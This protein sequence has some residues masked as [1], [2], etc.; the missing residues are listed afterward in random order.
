MRDGMIVDMFGTGCFS[1]PAPDNPCVS[2]NIW[3]TLTDS[4][5]LSAIG[6]VLSSEASRI[7][8]HVL[9]CHG[10]TG[11]LAGI[12]TFDH[13]GKPLL[14]VRNVGSDRPIEGFFKPKEK[15][16]IIGSDVS[17]DGAWAIDMADILRQAGLRVKDV[18]VLV[19]MERGA[20]EWLAENDLKLHS[21]MTISQVLETLVQTRQITEKES[22]QSLQY[23]RNNQC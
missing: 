16:L 20:K 13:G 10:E 19:D 9:A 2:F 12:S 23:I 15:V 6:Q 8:C 18:L 17:D 5:L 1:L 11:L 4:A 7:S 21:H 22:E 14:Y 3:E